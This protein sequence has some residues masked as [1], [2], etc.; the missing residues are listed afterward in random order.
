MPKIPFAAAGIRTEPPV[1]EPS[2]NIANPAPTETPVPELDP[3]AKYRSSQAL[4]AT[5][6][7]KSVCGSPNPVPYS[8]VLFLP[9]RIA[10]ASVSRLYSVASLSGTQSHIRRDAAVVRI[11][12][13]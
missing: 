13:V 6:N 8:Q 4:R 1:S 5:G 12:L 11:P 10:P 3:Q 2:P 9:S 7:G